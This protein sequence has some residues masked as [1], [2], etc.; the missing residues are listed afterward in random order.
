MNVNE[1]ASSEWSLSIAGQGV[2]VQGNDD[3]KQCIGII[4]NT[5][6]GT[7]PLRPD[8]GCGALDWIDQPQTLAIT[9]MT[10]EIINSL[11]IYEPRIQVLKV[12]PTAGPEAGQMTFSIKY[13]IK[14]T[15]ETDQTD[16][17]YGIR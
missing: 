6:K 15:V 10:P 5:R 9:K 3:I 12:I 14:N 8:F 17:V 16:V 2:I 13:S 11:A 4:L 7:D 1:I